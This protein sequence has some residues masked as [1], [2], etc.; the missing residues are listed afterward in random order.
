MKFKEYMIILVGAATS[1]LFWG[2]LIA[3]MMA[4]GC[5]YY[6]PCENPKYD[7][8]DDEFGLCVATYG[9][10]VDEWEL[11]YTL[12]LTED[13]YNSF[14]PNDT[15][16][17]AQAIEDSGTTLV[18]DRFLTRRG[19][20]GITIP[21]KDPVTCE[22]S[23]K[24][25]VLGHN[26]WTRNYVLGHEMLHVIAVEK[27]VPIETNASHLVEN[28][29]LTWANEEEVPHGFTVESSISTALKPFCEDQM[30]AQ[31]GN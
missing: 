29:F 8:Y 10:P 31:Y 6:N 2:L 1:L 11:N 22:E 23:I 20:R 26:C 14:F 12:N 25:G 4:A 18:Y 5:G 3:V 21:I 24:V 19:V 9:F 30:E 27:G 28:V 15:V 13:A 17:L 16:D 7:M